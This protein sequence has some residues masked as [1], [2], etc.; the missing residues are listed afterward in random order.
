M[1]CTKQKTYSE[2]TRIQKVIIYFQIMNMDKHNKKKIFYRML[3][4]FIKE[5]LIIKTNT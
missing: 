2:L 3:F 1:L 5:L 4:K